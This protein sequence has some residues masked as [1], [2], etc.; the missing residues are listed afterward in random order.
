MRIGDEKRG[1]GCSRVRGFKAIADFGVRVAEC[2]M[3]MIEER[4]IVRQF[5]SSSVRGSDNLRDRLQTNAGA[6]CRMPLKGAENL[7]LEQ[8]KILKPPGGHGEYNGAV[9]APV[10]VYQ[11]V[12]EP[13]H[14]RT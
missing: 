13:L 14:Q 12:P 8:F 7:P 1:F 6:L 10:L 5:D 9:D 3:G 11:D 2:G 4:S